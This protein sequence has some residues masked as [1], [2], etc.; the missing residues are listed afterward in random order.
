[1]KLRVL[2]SIL[3]VVATTLT[4]IHELE[5]IYGDH[6]DHDDGSCQVCIVGSH[7]VSSDIIDN[8]FDYDLFVSFE[9]IILKNQLEKLYYKKSDNHSNAPPQ[10]S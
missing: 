2:L 9:T 8:S 4:S 10:I 6:N 7:L 5:H 3:F 1:M